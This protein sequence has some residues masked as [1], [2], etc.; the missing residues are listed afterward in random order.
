[1]AHLILHTARQ[2]T[3]KR[4][5]WAQEARRIQMVSALVPDIES[6]N[7]AQVA[8]RLCTADSHRLFIASDA[9]RAVSEVACANLLEELAMRREDEE[10]GTIPRIMIR[11][12]TP[13]SRSKS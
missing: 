12:A 1:M 8:R 9:S 13:W 3:R 6:P 7:V 2:L 4:P 5:T 11:K 10:A